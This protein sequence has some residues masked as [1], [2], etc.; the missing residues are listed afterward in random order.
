[1]I[2]CKN[3]NQAKTFLKNQVFRANYQVYIYI[4]ITVIPG[5][6]Q[7]KSDIGNDIPS[8]SG[9]ICRGT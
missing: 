3:G 7:N 1:M 2:C 8:I 5:F 9:D 6:S 4:F